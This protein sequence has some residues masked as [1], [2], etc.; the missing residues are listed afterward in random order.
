MQRIIVKVGSEGIDINICYG[1]KT[2]HILT[3]K[4]AFEENYKKENKIAKADMEKLLERI[5]ILNVVYYDIHIYG[6]GIFARFKKEE[7]NKLIKENKEK[8]K[9]EIYILNQEEEKQLEKEG[10][11]YLIKNNK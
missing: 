10:I 7:K 8:T 4:I 9:R 5:K 11:K 1:E 2:E 3:Q 6:T